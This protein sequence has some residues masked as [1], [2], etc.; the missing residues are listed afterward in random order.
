MRELS[1]KAFY[2]SSKNN[3]ITEFYNPILSKSKVYKRVSAYF[4]SNIISMYS[5]GIENIVA[6]NGHI[7][8]IF[9]NEL[10]ERDY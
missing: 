8:F 10:N 2:N 9:S 3:I 7:Y 5:Q 1:I 4:D 6:Q